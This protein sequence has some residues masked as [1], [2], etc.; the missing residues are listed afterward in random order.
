MLSSPL[1]RRSCLRWTAVVQSDACY[2]SPGRRAVMR[3]AEW[4]ERGLASEPGDT[5]V[6]FP[7]GANDFF[8]SLLT[9]LQ[10]GMGT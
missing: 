9:F 6:R 2:S 1:C 5:L 8:P 3:T 10:L 7:R 4:L